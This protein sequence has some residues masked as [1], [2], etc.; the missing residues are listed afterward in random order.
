MLADD[1]EALGLDHDALDVLERE[2]IWRNG[3]ATYSRIRQLTTY[4]SPPS[5]CRNRA[6]DSP[7]REEATGTWEPGLSAKLATTPSSTG[8]SGG[9]GSSAGLLGDPDK[10]AVDT[11]GFAAPK[12]SPAPR[13]PL[14]S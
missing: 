14:P 5:H 2:A 12:G 6:S 10:L 4:H 8:E 11:G 3:A 13:P 9:R 1:V 7:R